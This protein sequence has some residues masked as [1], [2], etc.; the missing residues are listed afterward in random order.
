MEKNFN[1]N[2][3]NSCQINNQ[4]NQ[5]EEIYIDI[6]KDH[7]KNGKIYYPSTNFICHLIT[8]FPNKDLTITCL[9][10]K[11]PFIVEDQLN[12]HHFQTIINKV[13]LSQYTVQFNFKNK[14]TGEWIQFSDGNFQISNLSDLNN[15]KNK[16][17]NIQDLKSNICNFTKAS[18]DQFNNYLDEKTGLKYCGIFNN[19]IKDCFIGDDCSLL[20]VSLEL[21]NNCFFPNQK[22]L[23]NEPILN[24]I[25]SGMLIL[26]DRKCKLTISKID[27]MKY[28]SSNLPMDKEQI[29]EIYIFSKLNPRTLPNTYCA[30]VKV[31]LSDG[32]TIFD[33][34]N[35]EYTSSTLIK[36]ISIEPP[37][38]YMYSVYQQPLNSKI[39]SPSAFKSIYQKDNIIINELDI[40]EKLL[41]KNGAS[42]SQNQFFT[43]QNQLISDIL[44]QIILP[45]LY[46]KIVFRILDLDGNI[47]SKSSIIIEKIN[48]LLESHPNFE[49]DIEY[50]LNNC[51]NIP[52]DLNKLVKSNMYIINKDINI[53]DPS[54]T[55][56]INQS[57]YDFIILLNEKDLKTSLKQVN[58][59]LSPNGHLFLMEFKS[60]SPLLSQITWEKLL[61][62]CNYCKDFVFSESTPLL[63]IQAQKQSI[64]LETS[65]H[66]H[67]ESKSDA[68][69]ENVIIY[70]SNI[71]I[72]KYFKLV[73]TSK[74]C[75]MVQISTIKE[76]NEQL[77]TDQSIIYYIKTMDQLSID[78]Y[79]EMTLE[80][81][82]INQILMKL[83]SKCKH[84]LLANEIKGEN[85][86]SSS[87][88]GAARYFDEIPHL[89][90]Y[91]IDFDNKSINSIHNVINSLINSKTNW[92]QREFNIKNNEIYFE[93][94]KKESKFINNNFKSESYNQIGQ[95][96]INELIP[97]IN[98]KIQEKHLGKTVLITGQSGFVLEIIKWI[99][100][101]SDGLNNI[102]VLSKSKLKWE[103]EIII[104]KN[105]H[106]NFIFKRVD[107]G[108]TNEME[109][110]IN[111]VL[112]ENLNITNI[113]SI[114]HFAVEYITSD[115]LE[116]TMEHLNI[117]HGA[118]TMGA[119]NLHDQ[120][121]K[122]NWKLINFILASSTASEFGLPSQCS[123]V[124]SCFVLDSLSAFRKSI[125]LPSICTNFGVLDEAGLCS[126]IQII[127]DF[128]L[129]MGYEPLSC[130]M[131]LG[132]LDLQIQNQNN[133]PDFILS[134]L[135]FNLFKNINQRLHKKF[136]F[137]FNINME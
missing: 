75:K 26:V 35:V 19:G 5:V 103:L 124:C 98:Y 109:E 105:K 28:Y 62:E 15:I 53:Q 21:L 121:I 38:D 92:W 16:K 73:Y 129:K 111:E 74:N 20:V 63:K 85:Y 49:I 77:I 137:L 60:N 130:N 41:S 90:W 84:V 2:N 100:N 18:R 97:K 23:F 104:K 96:G 112:K 43:I 72:I 78:N 127:Q 136:N 52:I 4:S 76:L 135:N 55:V 101:Y 93:R 106:I 134:K 108:N 36:P 68:P 27:H 22:L 81:I 61:I 91:S 110:I 7:L 25:L 42:S 54:I 89:Q 132:A 66:H 128:T 88:I 8:K 122:R 13:S 30:S 32:T 107:V 99:I 120:S 114:F 6:S 59:L 40:N 133:S 39:E 9:Q 86:L 48:S 12:N 125:G 126:R 82:Q 80:Y 57:Y 37:N 79:K 70:G 44:K 11:S 102:I 50:T 14:K 87:V 58:K 67:L 29:S 113:D 51:C 24:I 116:I 47:N 56:G 34:E 117:S 95:I 119:I 45:L 33:I 17:Q 46:K 94:F 3:V 83:N 118:K 10:F 31:L 131:V 71:D 69:F 65:H 115:P 64:Q 1:E 123:Y